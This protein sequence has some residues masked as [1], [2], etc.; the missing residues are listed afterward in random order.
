MKS[1]YGRGSGRIYYIVCMAGK[2]F[3]RLDDEGEAERIEDEA[4]ATQFDSYKAAEKVAWAFQASPY[5]PWEVVEC[6]DESR[7]E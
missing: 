6:L 4:Q 5:E 2:H 1:I 3:L 7:R